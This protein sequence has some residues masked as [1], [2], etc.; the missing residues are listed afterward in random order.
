[1]TK[2]NLY[3]YVQAY[4]EMAELMAGSARPEF[5]V[6]I[7]QGKTFNYYKEK[8]QAILIAL[9][10]QRQFGHDIL[11]YTDAD[12]YFLRPCY[13]DLMNRLG[14]LDIL[15]QSNGIGGLATGFMV[16]RTTDKVIDFWDRVVNAK[17]FYEGGHLADEEAVNTFKD[18]VNYSIL[19]I[20]EYWTPCFPLRGG[21]RDGWRLASFPEA[22]A[23]MA[24]LSCV[25]PQDKPNVMADLVAVSHRLARVPGPACVATDADVK[26]AKAAGA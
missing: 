19:P 7:F 21:V 14:A 6:I 24:H 16:L 11:F 23:R 8:A 13:A 10:L 15:L 18:Q 1:M 9:K 26:A 17:Q 20:D 4:L 25:F 22:T 5:N 3:T 12:V 2:P